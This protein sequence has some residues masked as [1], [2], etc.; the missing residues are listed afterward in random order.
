MGDN[1]DLSFIQITNNDP[2]TVYIDLVQFVN[3]GMKYHEF[4]LSKVLHALL[5]LIHLFSNILMFI[6]SN[7]SIYSSRYLDVLCFLWHRY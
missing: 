6:F 1:G 7:L 2:Q 5:I 4:F 3:S